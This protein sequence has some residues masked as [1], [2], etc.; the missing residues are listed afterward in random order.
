MLL[1]VGILTVLSIVGGW[2]QFA[3]FWHPLTNW[4]APVAATLHS[5]EPTRTEEW[6]STALALGLG[7]GGIFVAYAIYGQR[8]LTAPRVPALHRALEHKLYFDELYDAVFYRPAAAL[9]TWLRKE[10]EEPI[11]LAAAGDLGDTAMD[12]GRAVG[13]MQTG[14]LRTYVFFLGAGTA[15]L[16]FVFLVTK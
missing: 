12:T 7:L 8:R 11:V 2:I 5:A 13:K 4:L 3:P 6:V 15:I 16:A 10:V 9:A 14:L 1:P